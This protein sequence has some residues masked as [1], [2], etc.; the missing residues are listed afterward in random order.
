VPSRRIAGT[1]AGEPFARFAHA[2]QA[3]PHR[4]QGRLIEK[5]AHGEADQFG[6]RLVTEQRGCG[7][8]A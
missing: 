1:R 6:G 7:G 5:R 2:L 3:Q 8:L 4:R